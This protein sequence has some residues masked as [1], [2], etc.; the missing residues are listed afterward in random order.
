MTKDTNYSIE[1]RRYLSK[2][3]VLDEAFGVLIEGLEKRDLLD[4]T[5]IVIFG[6]HYPYGLSDEVI[7]FEVKADGGVEQTVVMYNSP[8]PVTADMPIGLICGGLLSFASLAGFAIFK[9]IKR[10]A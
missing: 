2:L 4:D 6:D 9:M 7:E 3:K 8:I 1:M 5:V 10:H